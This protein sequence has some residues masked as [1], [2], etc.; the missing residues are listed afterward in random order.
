LASTSR[1]HRLYLSGGKLCFA[2]AGANALMFCTTE[3]NFADGAWHHAAHTRR[4]IYADG[5]LRV[6]SSDF[7][8][9]L[10]VT[11]F[12]AGYRSFDSGTTVEYFEGDLDEIRIW[13]EPRHRTALLDYERT[14]LVDEGTR[15]RLFGYYPLEQSGSEST[16]A[17]EALEYV[18][19]D[20]QGNLAGAGGAGSDLPAATLVGFDFATSP[21][22]E[23]GAF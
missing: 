14:R 10:E 20:C 1:E 22:I 19:P 4:G 2:S 16:A 3:A 17:N 23:P 6:E 9:A 15:R 13:R 8:D 18:A 11:T 12:T 21:W 7:N 5:T